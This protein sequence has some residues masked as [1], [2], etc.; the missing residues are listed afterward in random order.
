MHSGS[1]GTGRSALLC[2]QALLLCSGASRCPLSVLRF[3]FVAC[4]ASDAT[5]RVCVCVVCGQENTTALRQ[6][7]VRFSINCTPVL[8]LADIAELHFR[9]FVSDAAVNEMLLATVGFPLEKNA[10]R[11]PWNRTVDPP[12]AVSFEI[13]PRAMPKKN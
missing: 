8:E 12:D 10:E 11:L 5:D 13:S 3:F 6:K 2:V 7:D 1:K 9:K 4:Q